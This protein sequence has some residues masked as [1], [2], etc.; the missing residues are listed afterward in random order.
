[1]GGKKNIYIYGTAGQPTDKN[2]KRH[3]RIAC[4]IN[5]ATNTHAEY[6]IL[7]A[8]ELQQYLA[9][10]ASILHYK[11]IARLSFLEDALN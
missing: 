10:C 5:K 2:I 6:V 3:S 8:L 1:V 7:I 9:E 11:Y 4:W